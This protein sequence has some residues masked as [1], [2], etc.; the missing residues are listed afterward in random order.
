MIP[1]FISVIDHE[2]VKFGVNINH[3]VC[4]KSS[5]H[6]YDPRSNHYKKSLF[7]DN[8]N[9]GRVAAAAKAKTYTLVYLSNQECIS[10]TESTASLE[11]KI[12]ISLSLQNDK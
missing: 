2:G 12:K 10:L 6:V 5:P 11:N 8:D 7:T 4:Y 3:I 9:A 1:G